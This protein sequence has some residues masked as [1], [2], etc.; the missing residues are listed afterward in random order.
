MVDPQPDHA[1][2]R[3][4]FKRHLIA[5]VTH[6][7]C[8][9][10]LAL[11]I[12]AFLGVWFSSGELFLIVPVLALGWIFAAIGWWWA[13]NLTT[14]AKIG[15]IIF[16]TLLFAGEGY[17][18]HLY[19]HA[20]GVV[21]FHWPVTF[22]PPAPV[23]PPSEPPDMPPLN[24]PGPPLSKWG[25]MMYLCPYP[26]DV[27]PRNVEAAKVQIRRNAEIYGKALGVDMVLSDIPYGIRFDVTAN[28][29]DGQQRMQTA[30]RYTVQLERA[31]NGIFVTFTMDFIGALAILSQ[32]PTERNSEFEKPFDMAV[33]QLGFPPGKCRML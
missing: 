21:T 1:P 8:A 17:V 3:A 25:K 9:F 32:V 13:P 29:S 23:A 28:G 6:P 33:E 22:G 5:I 31:S 11:A 18:L 2:I 20:K 27:D 12:A 19:F 26:P 10:F 24:L 7:V 16:S 15:W 14:A 30:Q 4:F